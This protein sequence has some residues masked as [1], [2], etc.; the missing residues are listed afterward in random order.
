MSSASFYV[1]VLDDKEDVCLRIEDKIAGGPTPGQIDPL[2]PVHVK[3]IHITLTEIGHSEDPL[4]SRWTFAPPVLSAL[5]EAS[6]RKPDL[7]IVDYVY[8]NGEVAKV[9]KEKGEC[10]QFNKDM[11]AERTLTP[12]DLRKWVEQA[13]NAPSDETRTILTNL[14]NASCPVYLHTYTPKGL[15]DIVGTVAER[16]K[17]ASQVFPHAQINAIDT[18][19]ELFKNDV[20]DW[21]SFPSMKN[22]KYYP[23]QLAVLFDQVVKKEVIR[24]ELQSSRYLRIKRT[25]FSVSVISA[26]GAGIGFTGA[27]LGNILAE[28]I[29]DGDYLIGGMLAVFLLSALVV[30]GAVCPFLFEKW[31]QKIMPESEP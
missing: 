9:L 27:W 8:V 10:D 1:I 17:K 2:V 21:P 22:E 29:R 12:V 30:L 28:S 31:M 7:I 15:D 18:R 14:F 3:S 23:Y 11:M 26:L 4:K 6:V 19:S 13:A 20:F 25:T 24:K 16:I 5:M